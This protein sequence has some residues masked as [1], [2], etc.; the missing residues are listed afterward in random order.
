MQAVRR[1]AATIGALSLGAVGFATVAAG[2]ASAAPTTPACTSQQLST[3]LSNPNGPFGSNAQ[4]LIYHII[5]T[6]NG[7]KCTLAAKHPGVYTPVFT[8]YPNNNVAHAGNIGWTPYKVT[9]AHKGRAEAILNVQLVGSSS[10]TVPAVAGVPAKC[11]GTFP[12]PPYTPF[13]VTAPIHDGHA[14]CIFGTLVPAVAPVAAYTVTTR[15]PNQVFTRLFVTLPD[16][17]GG[18]HTISGP[19]FDVPLPVGYA[20]GHHV[21]NVTNLFGI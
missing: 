13:S 1:I 6:N 12:W 4:S 3:T 11:V 7:A 9:L 2:A 17:N 8:N 18:V 20:T 15:G 21:L 14:F 10:Y 16:S 19:G 5:V